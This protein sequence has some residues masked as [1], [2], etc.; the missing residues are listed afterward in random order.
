M[1]QVR[2]TKRLKGRLWA[3]EYVV[4]VGMGDSAAWCCGNDQVPKLV[5]SK[6][7]CNMSLGAE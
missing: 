3:S 2:E 5:G 1:D 6:G 7:S 4:P